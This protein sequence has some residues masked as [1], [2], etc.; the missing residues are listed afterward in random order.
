MFGHP[1]WTLRD[2]IAAW[3]HS[4]CSQE[5]SSSFQARRGQTTVLIS[6]LAG[7][8][9][10]TNFSL[11]TPFWERLSQLPNTFGR[12][13]QHPFWSFMTNTCNKK[14][15]EELF[16]GSIGLPPSHLIS[17][18]I[19]RESVEVKQTDAARKVGWMVTAFTFKKTTSRCGSKRYK[20]LQA[21][22]PPPAKATLKEVGIFLSMNRLMHILWPC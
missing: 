19:A 3:G 22:P 16:S 4:K 17:Q 1:F 2:F 18:W 14:K 11:T 9:S 20:L 12:A 6:K 10:I 15:C 13:L 5:T 8:K 7:I 21:P